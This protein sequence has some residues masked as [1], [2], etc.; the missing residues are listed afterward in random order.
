MKLVK[1]TVID[2]RV[3]ESL[4][5]C[6]F[7]GFRHG[8]NIKCNVMQSKPGLCVGADHDDCPLNEY[9]KFIVEREP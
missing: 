3:R 4:E 9:D 5:D 6:P 8:L 7:K 2:D 1:V